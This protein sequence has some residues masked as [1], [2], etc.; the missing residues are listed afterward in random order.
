MLS[1]TQ[2]EAIATRATA[3]NTIPII[4]DRYDTIV[5]FTTSLY[6]YTGGILLL[7]LIIIVN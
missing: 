7:L 6:T 3:Y 1:G 4:T 2:T 5:D